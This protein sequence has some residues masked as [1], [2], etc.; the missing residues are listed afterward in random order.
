MINYFHRI[1]HNDWFIQTIQNCHKDGYISWASK[2]RLENIFQKSVG[3]VYFDFGST[4]LETANNLIKE[5][6][7]L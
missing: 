7:N 6:D 3:D 5:I 4:E 1:K 2:D